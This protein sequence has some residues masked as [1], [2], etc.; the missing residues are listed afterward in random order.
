MSGATA[1]IWMFVVVLALFGLN[2]HQYQRNTC[3]ACGRQAREHCWHHGVEA[4]SNSCT[5]FQ[6]PRHRECIKQV[7][8]HGARIGARSPDTRPR[9]VKR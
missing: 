4:W 3:C 6:P 1:L 5:K 2:L 9:G 7:C 8:V